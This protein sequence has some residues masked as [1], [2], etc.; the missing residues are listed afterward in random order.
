MNRMTAS[1]RGYVIKATPSSCIY[2]KLGIGAEAGWSGRIGALDIF[3]P[4][5]YFHTYGYLPGF[6]DT[7][8]LRLSAM[9]QTPHGDALFNERVVSTMP[10]GMGKYSALTSKMSANP[11]QGRFTFDYAFPFAPLDWSGMGP[12]AYVRNLEC[13]IHGDYACFG[14]R[15][16]IPWTHLGGAGA[17]LCVVL[18]NLLWIPYDTKIGVKYYYNIGIPSNLNPHQIDMV[19]SIDL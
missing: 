18:G 19:F 12:V 16:N 3:K 17:E 9:L 2:P 8:G 13:T 11:F 15:K 7:H 14:G 1:V 5:A 4:N 10:R 6:M